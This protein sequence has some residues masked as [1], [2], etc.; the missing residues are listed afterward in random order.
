MCGFFFYYYLMGLRNGLC[1][2]ACACLCTFGVSMHAYVCLGIEAIGWCQLSLLLTFRQG[3]SP[4]LKFT[5]V[6]RPTGQKE[7]I[8]LS[9]S[10]ALG[11]TV[12][13]LGAFSWVLRVQF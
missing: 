1:V 2:Y 3:V 11:L 7:P 6:A 4:N 10:L 5:N 13:R 8:F 9:A 12:D